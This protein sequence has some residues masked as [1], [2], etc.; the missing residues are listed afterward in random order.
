MDRKEETNQEGQSNDSERILDP[1]LNSPD[2]LRSR[3]AW[4]EYI[5]GSIT[6]DELQG[7]VGQDVSREEGLLKDIFEGESL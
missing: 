4:K 7:I 6:S 2:Y 5:S 3:K 1:R